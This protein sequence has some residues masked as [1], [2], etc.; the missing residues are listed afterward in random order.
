[1]SNPRKGLKRYGMRSYIVS[2]PSALIVIERE[3]PW[4]YSIRHEDMP[5]GF[6]MEKF[7]RL[8]QARAAAEAI[9]VGK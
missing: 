9:S 3:R 5:S 6:Y 8:W 2:G 4:R 1:M 7:K